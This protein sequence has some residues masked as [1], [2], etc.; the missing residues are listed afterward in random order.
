M[1]S[2]SLYGQEV[3]EIAQIIFIYEPRSV[4]PLS[5]P[6]FSRRLSLHVVAA[7]GLLLG[8]LFMGMGRVHVF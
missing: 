2:A 5:R 4:A 8:S 6:R 7:A 1:S 3:E